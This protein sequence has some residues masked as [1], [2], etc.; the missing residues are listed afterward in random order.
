[1]VAFKCK[2]WWLIGLV[3]ILLIASWFRLYRVRD[4]LVF[5]GDEGRDALV[6]KRMIVD[7]RFTLLGPTAS[8]GGFYLGPIY[9]YLTLPFAWAWGLD[10]VGPAYFVAI[11]GIATVYLV[12]L[13]GKRYLNPTIGLTAAFLYSF[14]PLIVRY[15][16]SSWNPNPLPF[17]TLAGLMLLYEGTRQKKLLLSFLAGISLGITWQ[18]H[19]LALILAPVYLA[20]I[21]LASKR[22][23]LVASTYSLVAVFIGWILGFLPFLAFEI[24]HNFPNTRTVLEFITRKNGAIHPVISDVIVTFWQRI[25]LMFRTVLFWPDNLVTKLAVVITIALGLIYLFRQRHRLLAI[26]FLVGM[27]TFAFYQGSI[28]DYYFGWLFPVPFLILAI[29]LHR[30]RFFILV[31]ILLILA[32]YQLSQAFFWNKPNRQIDQ[33]AGIAD[34]VI[35]QAGDQP[36]NFAL[37]S[38]GNSDHAYRFFLEIKGHRPLGLEEQVTNQLIII[39]EKPE[40]ECKPLGNSLWE[41]AGFGRSEVK[42]QV[43]VNPGITIYRMIHYYD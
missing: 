34:V 41:I 6:W 7:H 39:C 19:Y 9:Y 12:Y 15:S 2:S 13:F 38:S 28:A 32:Y 1:M 27:F 40:P 25:L 16:R 24:R 42:A 3:A 20:I 35:T 37:I 43:T 36:F 26:W 30:L 33:T 18:L 8:V 14:A 5:L 29:T 23:N 10:P 17:F 21:L 4:Y 31:P 11:L 22:T